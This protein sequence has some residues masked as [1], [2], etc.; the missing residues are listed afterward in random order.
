[1]DTKVLHSSCDTPDMATVDS[2]AEAIKNGLVV[3]FPTETFYGLGADGLKE[4][5]VRKI[6]R[7]KGR[8]YSKPILLITDRVEAARSLANE[9]PESAAAL[10]KAFW[11]GPLTI[12]VNAA[13]FLPISLHGGSGK[14]GVRVPGC[15]FAR[16]LSKAVNGP[17]TATSANPSNQPPAV[18]SQDVERYFAGRIPLIV[19]GGVL[20]GGSPSTIVDTSCKPCQILRE[21]AVSTGQIEAILGTNVQLPSANNKGKYETRNR[22]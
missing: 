9:W 13:D 18:S 8:D 10:A 3:A 2:A 14:I 19:D 5:T 22:V 11:P 17:V 4:E 15:G 21:G 1:M 20:V 7:L 6:F 16:I 12:V